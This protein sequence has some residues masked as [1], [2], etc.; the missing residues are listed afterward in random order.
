MQI[1]GFTVVR[2]Y[3]HFTLLINPSEFFTTC[4]RQDIFK[5]LELVKG[6]EPPTG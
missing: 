5:R 3:P 1:S 4:T 6:I 2:G